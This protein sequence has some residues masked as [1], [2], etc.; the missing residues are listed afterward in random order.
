MPIE[1]PGPGPSYTGGG[2]RTITTS[3][4]STSRRRRG[5]C[6]LARFGVSGSPRFLGG[7]STFLGGED[8]TPP[9][10]HVGAASAALVS[11]LEP[12]AGAPP[13]T[14]FGEVAVTAAMVPAKSGRLRSRCSSLRAVAVRSLSGYSARNA[15]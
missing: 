15:R 7:R 3:S 1:S 13:D 12:A 14:P 11:G 4:S 8:G 5:D 10:G 6:V 9:Q 2:R